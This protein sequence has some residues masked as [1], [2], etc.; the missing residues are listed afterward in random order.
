MDVGS[1]LRSRRDPGSA[2]GEGRASTRTAGALLI[3]VVGLCLLG[4][5]VAVGGLL[6]LEPASEPVLSGPFRWIG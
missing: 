5:L 3:L 6:S 1:G 2:S 4:V